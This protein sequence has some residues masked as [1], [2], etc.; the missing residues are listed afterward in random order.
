M[1]KISLI[2]KNHMN[3][4]MVEMDS[5]PWMSVRRMKFVKFL[6]DS[7]PDT[8]IDIDDDLVEVLWYEFQ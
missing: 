2:I 8:S 7:Y 5:M 3:D 6:I 1:T 4:A